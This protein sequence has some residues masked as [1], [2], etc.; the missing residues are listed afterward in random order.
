MLRCMLSRPSATITPTRP[1]SIIR[2][3]AS[4]KITVA[5]EKNPTTAGDITIH[6]RYA[7]RRLS[8][9]SP[10]C[11]TTT[12]W[13]GAPDAHSNPPNASLL[14]PAFRYAAPSSARLPT[15][16]YD[17]SLGLPSTRAAINPSNHPNRHSPV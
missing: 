13:M 9:T 14:M 3:P 10:S 6:E 2:G 5:S 17:S 4:S 11:A 1:P 8:R 16:A 12:A 15:W 7:L